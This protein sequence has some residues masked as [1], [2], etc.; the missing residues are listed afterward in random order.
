MA[1]FAAQFA[2]MCR[3]VVVW[4]Q[5]TGSDSHNK[6][7]FAAPVVYSPF[8]SPGLGGLRSYKT[9]RAGAGAGS[10]PPGAAIVFIQV[11]YI[12]LLATPP[13]KQGDRVYIQG[14]PEPYPPILGVDQ[15]ADETG[16][17][18]YTKITLGSAT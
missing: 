15:P 8:T 10:T 18:V 17:K 13:I 3:M 16:E 6:S 1:A 4:E 12:Y 7:I 5:R 2:D 14:D 9:I 11:S